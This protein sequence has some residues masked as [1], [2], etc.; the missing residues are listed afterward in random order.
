MSGA[1]IPVYRWFITKDGQSAPGAKLYT[2][3]S[4]TDTPWPVYADAALTSARTQPVEADADG[5]F[6]IM[7]LDD[8]AYRVLITDANG[9]TIYPATDNIYDFGQ[10]TPQ[11]VDVSGTAGET[12]TAGQAAYLSDGSGGLTAG[13]WYK[14]DA[15]NDYASIDPPAIGMVV[16]NVTGGE[17]GTFRT[18][19]RITGLSGLVA[20]AT[21]YLS[22]TAGSL[23][24]TA[25]ANARVMG[26]ADSTT[27]LIVT[28]SDANP[29]QASSSSAFG[30]SAAVSSNNLTL[31]LTTA[32]GS[33]PTAMD[34]VVLTFRDATV[35]TGTVTSVTVS[36]ATTVVIPDTAT[37]GT[38]NNVPFRYWVVAF[39]D[40]GT[41]R[42]GVINCAGS[43]TIYPLS[44]WGIASSTT[45][46]TGADSAQVFYSG[47]GVTSK[48][49][50]VIG[51]VTYE[52][53]LATAGTYGSAPTRVQPYDVTVPLPGRAVQEVNVGYSTETTNSTNVAADTGLTASV[54]PTSAANR[55]RVDVHQAG[56]DK[57]AGDAASGITVR[58]LRGATQ[59]SVIVAAGGFTNSSLRNSFGTCSTSVLDA[60]GSSSAVTYKTTFFNVTNAA[61]VTV[62]SN[63]AESR[64]T[65]T[66][67]MG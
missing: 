16:A 52:S 61:S 62:Q 50:T 24:S 44:G 49:Y 51:Y 29:D 20:G 57:A 67:V 4:G 43:G 39:N 45:I 5:V 22:A 40:A 3:L 21:Y 63:S 19:G 56:C 15:D 58:L 38:S 6:P 33:T 47:T 32:S 55:V 10:I 46:G 27:S 64:M 13:R 36:A 48:A 2:Y 41:V 9:A 65:L 14:A 18:R 23:T 59:L 30:L 25:P 42:L 28:G 1:I 35:S 66:E 37:L 53:G 60:P 54:T 8:V 11:N 34:G 31:A 26:Q 17:S 7:Y 12:M